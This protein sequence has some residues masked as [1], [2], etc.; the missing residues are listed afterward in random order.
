[1]FALTPIKTNSE[2]S[3][4]FL[5]LVLDSETGDIAGYVFT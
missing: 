5:T 1:M 3:V 4:G 2:A